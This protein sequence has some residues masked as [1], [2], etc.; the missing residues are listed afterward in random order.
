M[1]NFYFHFK[2]S[3]RAIDLSSTTPSAS[4]MDGAETA[5]EPPESDPRFLV[6]EEFFGVCPIRFLDEGL[7]ERNYFL[8]IRCLTFQLDSLQFRGYYHRRWC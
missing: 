4:N 8:R 2:F 3:T 1:I 6:E 7:I 5:S